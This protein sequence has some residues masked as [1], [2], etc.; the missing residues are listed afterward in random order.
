MG[1]TAAGVEVVKKWMEEDLGIYVYSVEIG[2]STEEDF[3]STYVGN[4]GEQVDFVCRQIRERPEL[5]GGFNGI[6]FSQGS[7][8]MRGVLERC[9]HKGPKMARLI[10][11]GGQHQGVMARKAPLQAPSLPVTSHLHPSSLPVTSHLHPPSPTTAS[12]HPTLGVSAAAAGQ[13]GH[14]SGV[15]RVSR[16]DC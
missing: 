10:T 3:A 5:A 14:W 7:Q 2:G 4:V 1:N 12:A 8:F 11:L 9:Q 16:R 15:G 13:R 6:G